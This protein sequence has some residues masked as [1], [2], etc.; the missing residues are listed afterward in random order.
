MRGDLN[1]KVFLI[2]IPKTLSRIIV[3]LPDPFR[4]IGARRNSKEAQ[5]SGH[6]PMSGPEVKNGIK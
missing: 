1:V 4:E 2:K 3:V 5:Q 6:A